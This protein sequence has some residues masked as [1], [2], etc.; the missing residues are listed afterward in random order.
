MRRFV[1]IAVAVGV[2]VGVG[3]AGAADECPGGDWFCD[4]TPIPEPEVEPE[5]ERPPPL[6]PVAQPEPPRRMRIEVAEAPAPRRV[7][8]RYREWAVNLH[9]A[10]AL[11]GNDSAMSPDAGMS[12][13]GGALRFRLIPHI[14]F[15]GSLELLWGIDYNGYDRFE[16]AVMGSAL[17]F[18]NPRSAVQLYGLAGLGFGNA[19]L[20]TGYASNASAPRRRDETYFYFGAQLGVGV[21]ARITRHFVLGGDVLGFLRERRDAGRSDYPEFVDPETGRTTNASGGGLLRLG[22][23]Y[24]W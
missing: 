24:Y 17:F 12:G 22:A 5:P 15:E 1:S 19:W 13:F 20:D 14:A 7:R 21:E 18:A 6:P 2:L 4:P 10:V 3:S 16:D 9:G 8:R 23:S 11:M